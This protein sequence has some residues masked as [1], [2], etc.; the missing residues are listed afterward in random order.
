MRIENE[1]I[2]ELLFRYF[3]GELTEEQSKELQVWLEADQRNKKF[4]FEMAEWWATVHVPIYASDMKANF[5]KHFS[6][7]MLLE[8][9]QSTKKRSQWT[10]WSKIAA[11][12]LLLIS[13]GIGFYQLGNKRI[14]D[15]QL[16]YFETVTSMGTQ[17]KVILPDKSVIWVNA[18]SSLRYSKDFNKK[19]RLIYLEGEAYFEVARDTLKPFMVKLDALSVKVLG[20]KFNVKAYKNDQTIDVSLV[21]GK[22]NVCLGDEIKHR[23]ELKLSPNHMLSYNKE[24]DQVEMKDIEGHDA[25]DWTNGTLRFEEKSFVQIAKDLERKYNLQIYIESNRLKKEVFTGS[26]SGYYT[27]DDILREIDV[28]HK[29]IWKQ[30]ANKL[31]IK[32]K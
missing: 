22:V 2:E 26:F 20:T 21:S 17:S 25:Y 24:T 18:G 7:L 14:D 31:V 28:E 23:E 1:H 30:T 12:G 5:E 29:Y 6:G 3:A 8:G 4:Y 32:D 19:D 27:L 11:V 15:E 13:V 16:V 9:H 10:T